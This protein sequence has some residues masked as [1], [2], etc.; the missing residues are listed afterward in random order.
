MRVE[1]VYEREG[2]L[3]LRRRGKGGKTRHLLAAPVAL[4]LIAEHVEA[5][6]HGGDGGGALFRPVKTNRTGDLAKP[7][8]PESI[9]QTVVRHYAREV[10][11]EAAGVGVH[12]L[13]ATAATNALLQGPD[14]AKV[15]AW[16]GYANISTPRIYDRRAE[17]LEDSPTYRVRY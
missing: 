14:I 12:S 11:I 13:R 6:G 3:H 8:H 4:R 10:P 5:A 17:R 16:L 15:Q 9:Y 2:V 7:L 1:D